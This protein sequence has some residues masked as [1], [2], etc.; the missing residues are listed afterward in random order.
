M[1]NK[2]LGMHARRRHFRSAAYH[3]VLSCDLI[4]Q[5]L[6]LHVGHSATATAVLA[7]PTTQQ[8]EWQDMEIGALTFNIGMYQ[9]LMGGYNCGND[10]VPVPPASSFSP[11]DLNVTDWFASITACGARYAVLTVQADCG[12]VLY[13]SNVSFPWGGRYNYTV[14]ESPFKR[15]LLREFVDGARAAG[16]RPGVYYIVNSNA[17]LSRV[18]NATPAQTRS[19]ILGQLREIWSN[20][21][22]LVELWFDGGT[23]DPEL[24]PHISALLK[25]LQPNAVCFQGPTT[26]QGVRWAG[27]ESGHVTLPNWS[28]ASAS[29][30]F[31]SGAVHGAEFAPTEADV[32][33]SSDGKWR[34]S[35][36]Q[37]IKSLA[38]LTALYDASV[39]HNANL[40]LNFS[41]TYTGLFPPEAVTRYAQ[42]GQWQRQCYGEEN[43]L[44]ETVP[45]GQDW[46]LPSVGRARPQKGAPIAVG[47]PLVL[48]LVAPGVGTGAR[49]VLMED[50]TLGQRIVSDKSSSA[51]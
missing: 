2:Y 27:T 50:Q 45:G 35:P 15:D 17:L 13:P 21:G 22:E 40:L 4:L 14:R 38:Y 23:H 16:V 26:I 39:G 29:T 3:L 25:D 43:K 19:V 11:T 28:A 6:C 36:G 33:L 18:Y 5:A 30:D 46:S 47:M 9:E 31:G 20:Y 51:S 12:F 1:P 49:V 41:P 7:K 42:F 8:L 24:G 34:W 32:T 48:T 37:P 44:N 10:Q